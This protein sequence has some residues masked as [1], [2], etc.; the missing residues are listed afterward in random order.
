[1]AN[2]RSGMFADAGDATREQIKDIVEK[3]NFLRFPNYRPPE[4]GMGLE[5]EGRKRG[6]FIR[7]R[8]M[9][10]GGEP[11]KLTPHEQFKIDNAKFLEKPAADPNAPRSLQERLADQA[12]FKNTTPKPS[13]GG[14]G[15]SGPVGGGKPWS[16]MDRPKLYN[17]GG[18]VYMEVGGQVKPVPNVPYTPEKTNP[19][20]T[21]HVIKRPADE[22]FREVL[23]RVR[24]TPKPA[25][26][27]GTMPSGNGASYLDRP[28]L[29]SEGGKAILPELLLENE[30][31]STAPVRVHGF[32]SPYTNS[33]VP[34]N[35]GMPIP[36]VSGVHVGHD[37]N[38]DYGKFSLGSTGMS[39][40]GRERVV[41]VDLGYESPE[42]FYAKYNRPTNS[43][44][45][46]R[47]EMGYRHSFQSGGDVNID[48]MRLALMK[49]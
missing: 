19:N 16:P 2:N 3:W 27:A 21:D 20:T 26:S 45:P 17:I 11:P 28:H 33:N 30:K 49:G 18:K 6:G 14:G 12:F 5:P 42:G 41:G 38:T 37:I 10:E 22:G 40:N 4:E 47:Y 46:A 7:K 35:A 23:E 8:K 29:Y 48:A 36:K 24:N 31:P 32:S 25:G 39:A 44:A 1:M 9:N 13:G 15:G 43:P 34:M